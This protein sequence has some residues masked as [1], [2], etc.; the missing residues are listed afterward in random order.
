MY[1]SVSGVNL[2]GFSETLEGHIDGVEVCGSTILT[3]WER[4][5]ADQL[6]TSLLD[7]L[8]Y[9]SLKKPKGKQ[10]TSRSRE[11][12]RRGQKVNFMLA[13]PMERTDCGTQ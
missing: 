9:G 12:S 7:L 10:G 6:G 1:S 8:S 5:K 13:H 4:R 3:C 11:S 2:E